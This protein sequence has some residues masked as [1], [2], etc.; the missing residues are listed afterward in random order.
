M[1]LSESLERFEP[2]L[3]TSALAERPFAAL[4]AAFASYGARIEI[5]AATEANEPIHL[6]I[7]PSTQSD[8]GYQPQIVVTLGPNARA[9]IVLHWLG[10]PESSAW[11]NSVMKIELDEGSQLNLTRTQT[12]GRQQLHTELLDVSVAADARFR[13][14]SVDLG[15]RV[16]RNDICVR[17]IAPGACCDLAGITF[18]ANQQH[19]DNHISVEHLASHTSSEQTFRSIVGDRGRSV[20]SGKVVVSKGTHG[21]SAN[22]ASDNLLLADTGEIDAKPELEIN[23]DDVKCSHGATVGE[24]D[25]SQLFYLRSRGIPAAAARGLLT[26]GF[27]NEL[28]ERAG[29]SDLAQRVTEKFGLELPGRFWS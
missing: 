19:V 8:R 27:A 23:A 12:Y 21:I 25:E 15:G 22:Q 7:G 11:I 10:Q 24:L 14:T 18:A 16:T 9:E 20:F 17:L 3:P 28:L 5:A 1:T 4:N 6:L 29:R 26:I 2:A 13:L